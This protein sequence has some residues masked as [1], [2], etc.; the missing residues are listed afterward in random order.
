MKLIFFGDCMFGRNGHPFVED[1]FVNVKHLMKQ[2]SALFFNLETT[3]S[4]PLLGKE[5]KEDKT[6]NYQCTGEQLE[7]LRKITN[8]PIFVSVANNHSLD[9]GPLGHKNTMKFLKDRNFL[10]NSKQKV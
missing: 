8:K 6:F 4:R 10:C 5:Y 2:G 3:V 1:P 7:S 9:Y